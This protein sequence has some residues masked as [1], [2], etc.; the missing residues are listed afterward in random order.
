MIQSNLPHKTFSFPVGELQVTVKPR[1]FTTA[2][3]VHVTFIFTSNLDVLELLL[4]C[5]ATT[6]HGFTLGNLTMPYVPFSRQDRCNN[7]G[8][9][10]SLKVFCD[11]INNLKF[12]QVL[13][14][15]PHSD[16]TPALLNNCHVTPQW[17]LLA[18]PVLQHTGT[19]HFYLVAPD[20]GALKKTHKLAQQLNTPRFL[21][22]IESSKIRDTKT[23]EITGTV[24][25]AP[26]NP[27][28]GSGLDSS[29]FRGEQDFPI[30]Y[31]IP[32]DICD[33]GRTFIELAKELR[34]LGALQVHLYV[35]H[36]FYTKGKQVFDGIIDEVY[37]VNDYSERFK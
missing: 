6:R 21:G 8:E 30:V 7:P 24:V 12:E 15:D 26:G 33:G 20:A 35:T 37:A 14:Q 36:G 1:P 10:F 9:S 18:I 2:E 23:G 16:V 3:K 34:S 32:D 22:V 5:E 17:D 28:W 4:F 29:A 27:L 13:I 31:V 19:A 11:L 25:H